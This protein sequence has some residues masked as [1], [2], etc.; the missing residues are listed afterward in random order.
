[1]RPLRTLYLK[2]Y[3]C[4]RFKTLA[5]IASPSARSVLEQGLRHRSEAVREA[6]DE[7]LAQ[8]GL[9]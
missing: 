2:P 1:M 4:Q 5:R 9:P 8:W 7:A 6:C 3:S